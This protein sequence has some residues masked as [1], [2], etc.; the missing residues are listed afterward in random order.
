M[1]REQKQK[2]KTF[3]CVCIVRGSEMPANGFALP[4]FL[5]GSEGFGWRCIMRFEDSAAAVA[6]V[7]VYE[8][9]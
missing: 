7:R 6:A 2:K 9:G 8:R 1:S 4:F 3:S 5:Q